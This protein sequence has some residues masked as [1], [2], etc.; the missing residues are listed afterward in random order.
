MT[1]GTV[2]LLEGRHITAADK[3]TIIDGIAYNLRELHKSNEYELDGWIRRGKSRKSYQITRLAALY[4]YQVKIRENET[5]S[6]GRATMRESTVTVR[7]HGIEQMPSLAEWLVDCAAYS[8]E[9]TETGE[10]HVIP[11]CEHNASPTAK[12]L[13]LF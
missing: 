4:Q 7:A 2:T 8:T 1:R 5:D 6:N 9:L 10:Q 11:G 13:N 12:Q 3:R